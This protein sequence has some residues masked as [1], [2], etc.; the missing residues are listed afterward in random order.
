MLFDEDQIYELALQ[1]VNIHQQLK[2]ID[3]MVAVK[4]EKL[5]Q[6]PLKQPLDIITLHEEVIKPLSEDSLL[7]FLL[8][9]DEDDE[10]NNNSTEGM[11][12]VEKIEYL[13][14]RKEIDHCDHI[15]QL[16]L[17]QAKASLEAFDLMTPEEQRQDQI[18]KKLLYY[19]DELIEI[20]KRN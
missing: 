10:D 12:E 15:Y 16:E 13:K 11:S 4:K 20:S 9:N 6:I 7:D 14:I 2:L 19:R 18:K 3:Q 8:E 17:E 5:V 1:E